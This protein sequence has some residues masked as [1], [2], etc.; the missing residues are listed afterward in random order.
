[1]HP[2][3]L[4]DIPIH[5]ALGQLP[6]WARKGDVLVK[7]Y[8]FPNFA[9]G[10]AFVNRVARVAE[11]AGHH[12]DLDLRYSRVVCHLTTMSAGGITQKDLDLAGAIERIATG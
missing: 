4:T 11:A 5:R 6:G 7:S 12:P 2:E 9:A 8:P 1:M 3:R 10:V